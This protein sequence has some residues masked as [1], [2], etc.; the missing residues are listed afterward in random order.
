MVLY[1]WQHLCGPIIPQ[2][3]S[4]AGQSAVA[5]ILIHNAP[6]IPPLPPIVRRETLSKVTTT[7]MCGVESWSLIGVEKGPVVKHTTTGYTTGSMKTSHNSQS[8]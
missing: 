4:R 7:L 1:S 5:R 3:V 2:L 8:I 6:H